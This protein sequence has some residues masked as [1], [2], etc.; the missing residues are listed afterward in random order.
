MLTF[1]KVMGVFQEYLSADDSCEIIMTSRGRVVMD[2]DSGSSGWYS[3]RLC[4]T[5]EDLRDVLLESYQEYLEFCATRGYKHDAT[6]AEVEEAKKK[7]DALR[8][9]LE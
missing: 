2:W 4:Q 3:V 8:K 6:E 1:E 9:Q 7:C 5:P